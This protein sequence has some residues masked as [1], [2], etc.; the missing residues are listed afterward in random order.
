MFASLFHFQNQ[1]PPDSEPKANLDAVRSATEFAAL[2]FTDEE[3]A[4]LLPWAT[5]NISS[6]KALQG[7]P[8]DNS[9]APATIF[10]P[11]TNLA[12]VPELAA[13]DPLPQVQRPENLAELY[14]ADL[15]TLAA[16]I[17]SEQVTSVELTQL[18]LERLR[19]VDKD[20]HC[21]ISFTDEIAMAQAQ[22]MDAEL[23]KGKWRGPLHGIPYGVKD[24]CSVRGTKT[25]WGAAPYKD[26]VIEEDASVVRQLEEAGAVLVA[27][28]TLGAL[29][30]GDVWYGGKTRSPWNT[31]AGSSGSSAGSAAAVAAGALPFAIGSE[32]LGS[33][34]SPST[35]CGNSSLR[36]TFGRVAR[37]G[38]MALSWTMDKLGPM[39]RTLQDTALVLDAIHGTDGRD[40]TAMDVPFKVPGKTSVSGWRVG[41]S[42]K[43]FEGKE[44]YQQALDDL[45]GLGVE[46]VEVNLPDYPVWPLMIILF[47][48]CAAAF[49]EFTRNNLDDQLVEQGSNAWPNTFRVARLIP[50]VDYI[51]AQ[52]IRTLLLR[53]TIE[54]LKDVVAFVSPAGNFQTLGI[55]NLT[56]H[57]A[58]VAPCGFKDGM[59][60]SLTFNGNLFDESRLIALGRAWQ[61]R[62]DFHLQ[63]PPLKP[64][65]DQRK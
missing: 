48:E 53:D 20:L 45:R 64:L 52:R 44:E 32:T 54:K 10:L 14:W 61:E 49:D 55:T 41:Y 25:T 34:V 43:H 47:A 11:P 23:S 38:A 6:F 51:R 22:K 65:D 30:M 58:L 8:L 5:D 19:Q 46:L 12:N 63:R 57:P 60:V 56:G 7:V 39:C 50:A 42:P 26:Q 24:L 40:L 15:S 59:P 29:A 33:I 3:L 36:P 35:L 9:V 28:L 4:Q 13:Q 2:D 31:D 16:L 17:K 62:G 37:T 1:D 18:F 27:K 21:V